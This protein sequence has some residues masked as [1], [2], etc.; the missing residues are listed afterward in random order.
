VTLVA[1]SGHFIPQEKPAEFNRALENIVTGF[2]SA[3]TKK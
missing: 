1:G 3:T 2:E